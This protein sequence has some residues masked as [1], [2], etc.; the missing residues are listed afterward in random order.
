MVD[1]SELPFRMLCRKYGA[2]C[3]YTPMLHARLFCE[4]PKYRQEVLTTCAADRPLLV[5]FCANNP[6]F[7]VTAASLA[8][9]HA[10]AVD[11]NFGCPQR[12]AK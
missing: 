9:E 6:D 7:L 12:I 5:Q 2:T 10:D 8:A 4:D 1:Q 11:I 3:A